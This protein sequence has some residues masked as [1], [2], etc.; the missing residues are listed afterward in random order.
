MAEEVVAS[1]GGA[2]RAVLGM[3]S[4]ASDDRAQDMSPATRRMVDTVALQR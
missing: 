2:E 4:R 3:G 1:W